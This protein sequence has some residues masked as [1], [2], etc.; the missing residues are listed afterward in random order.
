MMIGLMATRFGS[1]GADYDRARIPARLPGLY[2]SL[3]TSAH[4]QSSNITLEALSP[5]PESITPRGAHR[6]EAW[7]VL[8]SWRFRAIHNLVWVAGF[9][10][11]APAFQVRNSNQ[12][13]LHPVMVTV[14]WFPRMDSN[15]DL[16]IQN[17]ASCR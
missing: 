13:E 8:I 9:E 2:R 5:P 12:T 16:Q 11:A 15:H 3:L 6:R 1:G 10:P 4:G 17:L 7:G 14:D